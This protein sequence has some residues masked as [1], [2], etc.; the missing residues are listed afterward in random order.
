MNGP[1]VDYGGRVQKNDEVRDVMVLAK[2]KGSTGIENT[3]TICYA[4]R[5]L[6]PYLWTNIISLLKSDMII[7][8]S[9]H[10]GLLLCINPANK[11]NKWIC[12]TGWTT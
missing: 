4:M 8:K 9:H 12:D 3:I 1:Y 6:T 2:Q 7:K 5:K 11:S 10:K